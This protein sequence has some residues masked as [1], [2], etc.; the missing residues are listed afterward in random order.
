MVHFNDFNKVRLD[1]CAEYIKEFIAI[2][3]VKLITSGLIRGI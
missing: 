3:G 1:L 2:I